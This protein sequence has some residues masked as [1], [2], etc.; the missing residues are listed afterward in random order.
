[1]I[2]GARR[3]LPAH[4]PISLR[5]VLAGLAGGVHEP[6]GLRE[7][8]ARLLCEVFGA[9]R[10]LLVGSGTTALRLALAGTR[11]II[12]R[13]PVALPAYSCYDIASAAEG[14]DVDVLLYDID[15]ATLAPDARSLARALEGSPAAVVAAPL[16]GYPVDME[17]LA[18]LAADAGSLLI[19]DAAQGSGGRLRGR[20]LGS[21][22]SLGILSFGRGK[23]MTAGAGGALLAHDESGERVLNWAAAQL[24]PPPAGLR[25][26]A[27][28]GMQWALGRPAWYWIPASLPFLRLGETVYHPPRIPSAMSSAATGALAVALSARD[29]EVVL[30]RATAERL[31][32]VARGSRRV[33]AIEPVSGGEPGYL[34]LP[35][36]LAGSTLTDALRDLAR[37]GVAPGYPMPLARLEPFARRIAN[38]HDV[39]EGA[40]TLARTLVT[41]PTHRYVASADLAALEGWLRSG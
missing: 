13:R 7:D 41:F 25:D 40:E 38:H 5:G 18:E 4:S 33:H 12:S 24:S 34:R 39:F 3:Q 17:R 15:R 14:A 21:F 26:A 32:S 16:Y 6:V 30:R 23:G 37:Y 36:R 35:L 31:L 9:R 2:A 11:A 20:T 19:E 22:G 29:S 28:L 10:A 1:V 27:L 8:M